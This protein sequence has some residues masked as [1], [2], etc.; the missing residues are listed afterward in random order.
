MHKAVPKEQLYF[1]IHWKSLKDVFVN[2]RFLGHFSS[3]SLKVKILVL[4][5]VHFLLKIWITIVLLLHLRRLVF[6]PY[7]YQLLS[8]L[9]IYYPHYNFNSFILS[10]KK[11]HQSE[12]IRL[13]ML[14]VDLTQ[15]QLVT[16]THHQT[17]VYF[18]TGLSQRRR[19][20][21]TRIHKGNIIYF[22]KSQTA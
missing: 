11:S 22:A 7:Y 20:Q 9:I 14:T 21:L 16:K 17:T 2:H 19:K 13:N 1:V 4:N 6:H 8:I 10:L 18:R 12:V 15:T 3:F 5:L